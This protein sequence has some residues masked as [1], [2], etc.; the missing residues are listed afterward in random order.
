MNNNI[1]IKNNKNKFNPDVEIKL[2]SVNNDREQTKFTLNK[3]IYNPITGVVPTKIESQKD[4][5]LE[6]DNKIDIKKLVLQKEAER[7]QQNELYKS[8]ATA[9]IINPPANK[10]ECIKTY[11]ELKYIEKKNP[12]DEKYNNILSGLKDLGIIK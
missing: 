5:V 7:L 9:K 11:T 2:K 3:T 12:N 8:G 10:D 1:F 6:K 4:L